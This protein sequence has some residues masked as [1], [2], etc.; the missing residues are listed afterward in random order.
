[1]AKSGGSNLKISTIRIVQWGL[2]GLV[3]ITIFLNIAAYSAFPYVFEIFKN[4]GMTMFAVI[5]ACIT[6]VLYLQSRIN[7][8]FSRLDQM[9]DKAE[10]ALVRAMLSGKR[11]YSEIEKAALSFACSKGI[12]L[13]KT[14]LFKALERLVAIGDVGRMSAS[15]EFELTI[16]F[17]EKQVSTKVRD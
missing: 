9:P 11:K 3:V 12:D 15:D 2:I 1:M 5:M 14:K 8:I 13:T 4:L 10:M 6:L 16:K 7:S 17:M